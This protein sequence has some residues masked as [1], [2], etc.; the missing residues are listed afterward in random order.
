VS[1]LKQNNPVI[2]A[3][4]SVIL[5]AALVAVIVQ[6]IHIQTALAADNGGHK[7]VAKVD[8]PAPV[9]TRT[10]DDSFVRP[11]VTHDPFVHPVASANVSAAQDEIPGSAAQVPAPV[12]ESLGREGR[13]DAWSQVRPMPGLPTVQALPVALPDSAN[14]ANNTATDDRTAPALAV[15]TES[16]QVS[17]IIRADHGGTARSRADRSTAVIERSGE[18]P[19]TA[20][21]G[22]TI[23]GC[24]VDAIRDQNI[25]VTCS[26][27]LYTVPLASTWTPDRSGDA[28]LP[29]VSAP[30]P[31]GADDAGD[32]TPTSPTGDRQH[33][34]FQGPTVVQQP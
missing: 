4:L 20:T 12:Q 10:I 22:D 19:M 25:V 8:Q 28:P 30:S 34:R 18:P 15:P 17:A 26:S 9:K 27:A 14:P 13:A 32:S 31:S 23:D 7:P 2:V 6:V 11:A 5:I 1:F 21:V 29:T 33:A 3:A 24:T 16:W